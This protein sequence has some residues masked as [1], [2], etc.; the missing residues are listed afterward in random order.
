MLKDQLNLHLKVHLHLQE[1][2]SLAQILCLIFAEK[3]F[4]VQ[5]KMSF[6]MDVNDFPSN[7]AIPLYPCYKILSQDETKMEEN[8]IND[9]QMDIF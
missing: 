6:Q 3:I 9:S 4:S 7:I 1:T 5:C 2:F 8:S